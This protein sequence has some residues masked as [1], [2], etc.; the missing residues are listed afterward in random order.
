[1]EHGDAM[2]NF[3]AKA[4]PY[5]ACSERHSKSLEDMH[6]VSAHPLAEIVKTLS[7]MR[8]IF[9]VESEYIARPR[10]SIPGWQSVVGGL[11]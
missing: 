2:Q 4:M 11:A 9:G 10:G 3:G 7:T 5:S 8:F 6:W 1:M